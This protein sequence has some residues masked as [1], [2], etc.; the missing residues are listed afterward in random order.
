M[1]GP[2][3]GNITGPI[4]GMIL[5]KFMPPHLGHIYL[6]EFAANYVDKLIIVV[7]SL[8]SEP[9]PGEL[10]Y[11]WMRDLFPNARVIH[12]TD[13]NP[14]YPEEH[15][16]FWQIWK[17]SLQRILPTIPNYVFASEEYGNPLAEI[18]G[19]K[20]IPVNIDRD[21]IPVS[22][23]AVREDPFKN[24]DY[25][26]RCVRPYF[27]KRICIFGPESTGKSTLSQNLAQ[28]FSTIAVPEYARTHIE[29]HKGDIGLDDIPLIARGQRAS[30]DALARNANRLLFCDT[31]LL[32]T[33]I[34]SDWLFGTCPD[35]LKTEADAKNYDLYL[36][37]DV[38]VPW[39]KDSVRYL[40]NERKSFLER[41]EKELQIRGRPYVL[42]SGSWEK[43]LSV[44]IQAVEQHCLARRSELP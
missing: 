17:K 30:E 37:T 8:K 42:L 14:Q 34:W 4:T 39:I 35:W 27:T 33:T 11:Q 12:L 32:T 31:D 24:W 1:T 13:E 19:A 6:A 41:C 7:G 28:H 23:T 43:R 20:F 15:P 10:R 3:T 40:P 22:G 5:G 38:D 21:I 9:I 2:M 18:L 16:D 36:L 25:L 29:F 44:A 26:P